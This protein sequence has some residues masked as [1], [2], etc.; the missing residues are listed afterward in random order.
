MLPDDRNLPSWRD[1][2]TKAAIE[3]FVARVTKDGGP[4]YVPPADRVAVFDNDGTLWTERP[5]P[6]QADFLFRRIGEMAVAD[7]VLAL[8][9]PWKAVVEHDDAWLGGAMTKHYEGDDSDLHEMLA[10][11]IGA[12]AGATIEEFEAEAAGFMAT[13]QHPQL[14]RPY[15]TCVFQP[16]VELLAYLTAHGF[17]CIIA[18]GGG[19]DFM[20]VV[21][22]ELYGI[23]PD[24][25]MGSS[26][27]LEYRDDGERATL[28]HGTGLEL[29]DDGEAKPVA[30]WGRTGRRPILAAGNS[31]GDI[32]M[33]HFAR[34]AGRPTLQLLVLHDDADREFAYTSGADAALE[35]A[36]RHDWTVVSI[37]DDWA[38]VFPELPG[39]PDVLATSSPEPAGTD[40]APVEG[41]PAC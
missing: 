35:R 12:Y 14:G 9:Q 5:L 30:V 1:T 40:A 31:N 19:R 41:N 10:G 33:I 23:P 4:D 20:R 38:I 7:P 24:R 26:V 22:E 27:A 2:P 15:R 36:A 21:S 18:S 34:G 28:V 17:S 39:Q 8:R 25:V 3:D 6:I 11:I 29:V 32:P 13:G 37:K 16:M